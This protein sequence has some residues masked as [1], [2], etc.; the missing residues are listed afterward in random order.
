[1]TVYLVNPSHVS[2]GIDVITPR[3]LYVL[4]SAT[5]TKYGEPR[6]VDETLESFDMTQIQADDDLKPLRTD[7]EFRRLATAARDLREKLRRQ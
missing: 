3:W 6:L 7:R 1:M 4:A 2:F 5:P